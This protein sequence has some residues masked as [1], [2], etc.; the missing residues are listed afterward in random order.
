MHPPRLLIS[1]S[2]ALERLANFLD[3][4]PNYA[5]RRNFVDENNSSVSRLSPFIR[6]RVILEEEV[7]E[8]ALGRYP[9]RTVEKFVQEVVWRT[10]WKGWLQSRPW[11][12]EN[13]LDDLEN[14]AERGRIARDAAAGFDPNLLHSAVTGTTSLD[15]FNAW[16]QELVSTGYLHNHVRMWFASIWIFTFG[17][18]WQ[19]GAKFF[20]DHLLD[21]DPAANT[22]SWRWVAGLQTAGKHYIATAS[23]I[24]RYTEQHWNPDQSELCAN[25]QAISRESS[26]ARAPLTFVPQ[27]ADSLDTEECALLVHD[28]DLF[29]GSG[30]LPPKAFQRVIALT[31]SFEWRAHQPSTLV[32][33]SI[34][35]LFDDALNR[36]EQDSGADVQVVADAE[37]LAAAAGASTAIVCYRPL[38]G[39]LE[40]RFE[41]LRKSLTEC[42]I[43]L[44][45]IDR[46]YDSKLFPHALRGFF[47]YWEKVSKQLQARGAGGGTVSRGKR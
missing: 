37:Q 5:T 6:R 3:Q 36:L 20:L 44:R 22:L 28:E 2:V 42:G 41:Q 16:S 14:L 21:G 9:F 8:Q 33:E 39:F 19:L 47:P 30:E 38:V 35:T 4:A 26:A 34:Q 25:P 24:R 31:P 13:Y 45:F 40:P 10:Y 12:W 27:P 18:P 11:V 15:Y 43:A 23:N 1:R 29:H 46:E 32:K 17:L 7:L